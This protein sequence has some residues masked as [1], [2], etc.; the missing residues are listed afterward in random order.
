M[1]KPPSRNLGRHLQVATASDE[2]LDEVAEAFLKQFATAAFRGREVSAEFVTKVHAY[3]QIQRGDG[4][5]FREAMVDPLALIL[6]SPRFLYLVNPD[7]S[8][9]E[10]ATDSRPGRGQPCQPTGCVSL[11]RATR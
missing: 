6:S 1:R 11:E 7:M 4:K 9:E 5:T 2:A 10:E 8:D 3:Y